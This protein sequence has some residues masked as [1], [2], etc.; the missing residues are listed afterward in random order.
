MIHTHTHTQ[1]AH[2][3]LT[4]RYTERTLHRRFLQDEPFL[5]CAKLACTEGGSMCACVSVCLC[6]CL[7]I[8]DNDKALGAVPGCGYDSIFLPGTQYCS[9]TVQHK[10]SAGLMQYMH[11]SMHLPVHTRILVSTLRECINK[12]KQTNS[13][14]STVR[15][16]P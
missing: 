16:A 5:L 4:A 1:H 15:V 10:C 13:T 6:V 11:S 8:I 3:Q 14:Y 12:H 2:T 7:Q 9:R